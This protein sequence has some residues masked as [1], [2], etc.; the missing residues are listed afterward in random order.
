[1]TE[2]KVPATSA[3]LGPGY[4]TLGLAL[5]LFNNFKIKKRADQKLKIKVIDQNKEQEIKIAAS[6]NLIVQAYQRYFKFLKK[7]II[8]AEIVEEMNSPLARGLGSSASAIIGGLAA[9][10][11]VSG[12]LITEKDFIQLAVELEKHPDNVVPALVGGLT[13]N[14]NC[15]DNYDYYKIDVDQNL[16]CILLVPDY[17]LKTEKLRQV[18]PDQINYP[19]VISNL[20]RISLL[21]AAF[22]N[23]DYQLLKIAMDDQLHQPYRKQLIKG[24]DKIIETAYI[25]GA[26]GAALSGAGPT[27]LALAVENEKIIAA[28]MKKNYDSL[29]IDS[30]F[31]IIKAYNKSL[32]QS[33]KEEILKNG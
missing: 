27:I 21:T 11:V 29:A 10:A 9:A 18:L 33:L 12:Q 30:S 20:S 25:N 16:N 4:D 5:T 19:A 2:I 13:V 32:Y 3:N 24:F 6:D 8:G 15:S 28:E 7:D 1:M 14:F 23:R 26:V 31:Y 22:I 17:E